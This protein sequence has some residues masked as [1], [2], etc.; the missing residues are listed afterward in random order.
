MKKPQYP[1]P[2]IRYQGY[3][4]LHFATERQIRSRFALA[5]YDRG[6]LSLSHGR[7]TF[8][9]MHV[10]VDC[11]SVTAVRLVRKAFPWG[12]IA[13][14]SVIALIL[15]YSDAPAYFTWRQPL[16]YYILVILLI[17]CI[18]QARER[19]VEVSYAGAEEPLRAYFRREPIFWGSGVLRTR[20]LCKEIEDVVLRGEG[21]RPA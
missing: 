4:D 19:W 15:V 9:G 18:K 2:A 17:G 8:R 1:E 16:P 11:P 3:S 13:P 14:F 7:I 20:K 21:S 12:I 6:E 10:M 5:N